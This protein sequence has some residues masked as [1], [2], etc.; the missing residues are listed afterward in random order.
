[1]IRTKRIVSICVTFILLLSVLGITSL[2]DVSKEVEQAELFEVSGATAEIKEQSL[3]FTLTEQT[4][5][6]KF[7]KPLGA[8]GFS[9]R[10]NGVE[11]SKK[12]LEAI[13]LRL[14]DSQ[15]AD[16]SVEVTFETLSEQYTLVNFNGEKREYLVSGATYA[17]NPSD[18]SVRFN[19]N[20]NN[21]VDDAGAFSIEAVNY[22]NG[23]SF[24][25]FPS[26]AVNL[27]IELTGVKGG[28]FSLKAI[29]EQPFGSE[30]SE[31]SNE[32][33]LCV[34]T[35]VVKEAPYNS[36]VVLK[37]VAAYDVFQTDSSVD[38]TVKTPSGNILKAEDGTEL[39]KVDGTKSY[40]IKI[41]E[42]GQYRVSYVV[43]DGIN[44]SRNLGY[45]INVTDIGAPVV[46]L[47]EEMERFLTVG[48]KFTFPQTKITDN[49]EG[50]CTTWINVMHPDGYM[51]CEKNNFT[52]EK[53]GHYTITFNAQD[54]N[55]NIGRLRVQ[56]Y[57][58]R[59]GK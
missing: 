5:I 23:E 26:L 11:D 18:I 17:V 39:S 56:V 16:R 58:E 43:S 38:L 32:P 7:K 9:F 8:S 1:M 49:S 2:A 22:M 14:S 37:P 44:K 59:S 24:Q 41:S 25:G 34:P 15:D 52:P 21:F 50:E 35:D 36:V 51:S 19:D 4:A 53:E 48:K 29:N 12:R 13:K 45:Q 30:Y 27:E 6:I 28:S 47:A 3:D 42:Y 33:L 57:A 54:A 20:T 31:D 55:G 46:E 40:K 10:W